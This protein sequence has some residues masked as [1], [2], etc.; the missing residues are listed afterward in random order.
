MC[1]TPA[2]SGFMNDMTQVQ[3]LEAA[4]RPNGEF[5]TR[6]RAEVASLVT[7]DEAP[8]PGLV[9]DQAT[10]WVRLDQKVAAAGFAPDALSGA[11]L[12]RYEFYSELVDTAVANGERGWMPE[13][14]VHTN[15]DVLDASGTGANGWG[16]DLACPVCLTPE[17]KPASVNR[18][19]IAQAVEQQWARDAF[20]AH[21]TKVNDAADFWTN[22]TPASPD[23]YSFIDAGQVDLP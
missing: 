3:L 2:H 17:G 9:A 12:A 6:P 14:P 10:E 19:G 7:L 15:P 18:L 22:R 8:M 16:N 23:S 20:D 11:E 1:E 5:G 13:C 4:R 21:A